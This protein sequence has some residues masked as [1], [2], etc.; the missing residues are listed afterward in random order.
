MGGQI[1]KV[2]NLGMFFYAFSISCAGMISF[3]SPLFTF[4]LRSGPSELCV[5][6]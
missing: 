6:C 2:L 1:S 5:G 3:F 4:C